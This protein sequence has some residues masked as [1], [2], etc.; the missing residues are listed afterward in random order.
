MLLTF[1]GV[2]EAFDPGMGTSCTLVHGEKTTLLI[3]CGYACLGQLYSILNSPNEIDTIYITHFHADHLFGVIP[4]LAAWKAW[5]RTA[6][7]TIIS[8][9]GVE[10]RITALIRLGYP[11]CDEQLPYNIDYLETVDQVNVGGMQ[12]TFAP[13]DHSLTNYAVKISEGDQ[14]IGFSGDGGLTPE[15]R[16]LFH[17]C[18]ILVHEAFGLESAIEGHTTAKEVIAYARSLPN[19]QTLALVHLQKDERSKHLDQFKRLDNGEAFK[20]YLP[21][22]GS[23]LPIRS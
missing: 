10:E 11:H 5:G 8:Q 21:E 16:E 14:A 13:S 15:T 17:D 23:T 1:I 3:D 7:L 2:G 6:P 20:I 12:L 18:H 4:L 22:P 19:L 9:P